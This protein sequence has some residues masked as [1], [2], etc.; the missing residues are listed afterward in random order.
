MLL[1]SEKLQTPSGAEHRELEKA[2]ANEVDDILDTTTST[3]HID[4][5]LQRYFSVRHFVT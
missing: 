2:C 5:K 1:D 3:I 4:T